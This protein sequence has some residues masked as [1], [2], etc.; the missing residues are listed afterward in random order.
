VRLDHP[1]LPVRRLTGKSESH[2]EAETGGAADLPD[3]TAAGTRV[4]HD[5][6]TL[7]LNGRRSAEIMMRIRA[8]T[9]ILA[10]TE[11]IE[12]TIGL[13]Q[14]FAAL[15]PTDGPREEMIA[16]EMVIEIKGDIEMTQKSARRR[17]RTE[18]GRKRE[19]HPPRLPSL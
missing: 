11:A 6:K 19:Q 16:I 4:V 5:A 1:L 3:V 7:D 12:N 9:E 15:P 13:V 14:D 8:E 18:R 10:C 2:H 17:R